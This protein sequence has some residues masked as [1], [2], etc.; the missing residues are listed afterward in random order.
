MRDCARRCVQPRIR[1]KRIARLVRQAGRRLAQLVQVTCLDLVHTR[2]PPRV[3]QLD[4]GT[5]HQAEAQRDQAGCGRAPEIRRGATGRS[6]HRRGV[7]SSHSSARNVPPAAN[8]PVLSRS[9]PHRR[10]PRPP[11]PPPPPPPPPP[12]A[13]ASPPPPRR[14]TTAGSSRQGFEFERLGQSK[15]VGGMRPPDRPRPPVHVL[16][17][18]QDRLVVGRVDGHRN[19]VRRLSQFVEHGL[20]LLLEI[21]ANAAMRPNAADQRRHDRTGLL[22][23]RFFDQ[24]ELPTVVACIATGQR[25][26]RPGRGPHR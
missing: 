10:G 3:R 1:P 13:T 15:E 16:A 11:R 24:G 26:A 19:H 9:S 20:K 6:A 14:R 21:L 8:G 25:P 23:Q 7:R 12:P 2:T 5:P 4:R 18:R 22:V 17:G